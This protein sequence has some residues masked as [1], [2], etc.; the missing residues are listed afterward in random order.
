MGGRVEGKYLCGNKGLFCS[1]M[2]IDNFISDAGIVK[3]RTIA[4]ELADAGHVKLNGRRAK[5]GHKVKL[6][7]IIEI[8][9]KRYI[10]ARIL[11]LPTGKSIP[12]SERPEYF[13]ILESANMKFEI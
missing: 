3:R 13:E 7:D 8:T 11:K 5:P 1:T 4:K 10:K 6:D 12:K 2:R 9:G